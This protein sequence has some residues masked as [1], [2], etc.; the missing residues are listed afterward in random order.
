MFGIGE[1]LVLQL[2]NRR[3]E[4]PFACA[5]NS[6]GGFEGYGLRGKALMQQRI[7]RKGHDF[8][9]LKNSR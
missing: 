4:L 3:D 9:M 6:E 2:N 8:G 1:K 5:L 7:R